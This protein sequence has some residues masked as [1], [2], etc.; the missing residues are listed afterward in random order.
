MSV[1]NSRCGSCPARVRPKPSEKSP[2]HH[3]GRV[4]FWLLAWSHCQN[5]SK[6]SSLFPS[7]R[8]PFEAFL[9]SGPKLLSDRLKNMARD[10]FLGRDRIFDFW[11]LQ[12]AVFNHFWFLTQNY[13]QKTQKHGARVIFGSGPNIWF[14]ERPEI[15]L[16]RL[17]FLAPNYCQNNS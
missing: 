1:A 2:N 13:C 14:L 15:V 4:R 7:S 6:I 17:W 3:L 12:K 11:N 9:V 10:L 16:T 5:G 8:K